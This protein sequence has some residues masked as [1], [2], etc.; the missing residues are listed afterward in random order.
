MKTATFAQYA[1]YYDLFYR[2]KE[3]A[4]EAA[5]VDRWLR[6]GGAQPGALLD[7][8]CGTGRHAREFSRLGWRVTG[9]DASAEMIDLARASTPAGGSVD[10]VLGAGAGFRL[11]RA[12]HAAVSLFHVASY[13]TG[14]SDLFAMAANVRRHLAPGGRFVFDFWHGPGVLADP[15]ARRERSV[16]DG[17]LRVQRR[18]VPTHLPKE[19]RIDVH[20]DMQID[21]PERDFT[22]RVTEVHAMRYFFLP[23]IEFILA[24]AGFGIEFTRAGLADQPLDER[25]WYALVGA[26]AT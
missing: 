18:S 12:F 1:R 2:G 21:D 7:V 15:P 20:Y 26:I 3:Y 19:C 24:Q 9:V 23:E 11:D 25:S 6:S 4:A 5:L 14:P 13:H 17:R 22:G 8:G 10:Y 16:E